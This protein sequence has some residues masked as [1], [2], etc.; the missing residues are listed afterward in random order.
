MSFDKFR[1]LKMKE[2]PPALISLILLVGVVS[3]FVF[4]NMN[5]QI[6]ID[7]T[8]ALARDIFLP[9]PDILDKLAEKDDELAKVPVSIG[10]KEIAYYE[11][12]YTVLSYK[13]QAECD[14]RNSLWDEKRQIC[15]SVTQ[16]RSTDKERVL[17]FKLLNTETGEVE[18][19]TV[20]TKITVNG[21]S[22]VAPDG[23]QIEIVERPNGIKWNWWNTLYQVISPENGVVVKNN[24][25]REEMA[26]VTR[27]VN[28]KPK[29]ETKKVI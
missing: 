29:Q 12:R 10:P 7:S 14:R 6:S 5:A 28:G 23:Y 13:T 9:P 2:P 4:Q 11:N 15:K 8:S 17:G 24:Y 20:Q 26:P 18:I 19:M 21:V 1:H 25:P 16:K 22:I 3:A 27:I